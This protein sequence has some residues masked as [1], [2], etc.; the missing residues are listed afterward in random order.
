LR[1]KPPKRQDNYIPGR[2]IADR[3]DRFESRNQFVISRNGWI[4]SVPGARDVLVEVLLDSG[5]PDELAQLGYQLTPEGSGERILAGSIVEHFV[6]NK[7]GELEPLTAEST[8][9]IASTVTH[10]GIVKTR[11]FSFDLP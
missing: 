10:A 9:P 8:G 6:M 2:K 1:T 5:L 4:I 11:R 7:R 3:K